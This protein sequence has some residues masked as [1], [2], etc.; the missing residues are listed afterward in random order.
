MLY[1]LL[2]SIVKDPINF[3]TG[4]PPKVVCCIL[5]WELSSSFSRALM[6]CRFRKSKP[7]LSLSNAGF[8]LFMQ[9][10]KILKYKEAI[11]CEGSVGLAFIHENFLISHTCIRIRKLFS[12]GYY[13]QG[14]FSLCNI[15]FWYGIGLEIMLFKIYIYI[16]LVLFSSLLL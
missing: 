4:A 15:L 14:T 12:F 7:L 1:F 8:I 9:N 6:I 3:A 10:F 5:Q 16:Y 13:S 11:S 2:S